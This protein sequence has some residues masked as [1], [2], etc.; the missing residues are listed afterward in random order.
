MNECLRTLPLL[1]IMRAETA[2]RRGT[3]AGAG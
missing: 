3:D 1:H 2:I